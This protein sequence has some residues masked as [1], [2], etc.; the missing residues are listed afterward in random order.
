[1]IGFL[2]DD[3]R[4]TKASPFESKASPIESKGCCCLSAGF[5]DRRIGRE[6]ESVLLVDFLL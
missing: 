3:G 2:L 6:F 4:G 1:M 5:P